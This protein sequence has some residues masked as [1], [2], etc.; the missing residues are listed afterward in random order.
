M[1][2]RAGRL[3]H[4]APPQHQK[5]AI[6]CARQNRVVPFGGQGERIILRTGPGVE[7]VKEFFATKIIVPGILTRILH[8][9]L[10]VSQRE[11]ERE[12][13]PGLSPQPIADDSLV[14]I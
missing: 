3:L 6:R 14:A 1:R 9:R 11:R 4:T 8:F 2:S 12:L 5:F 7:E 10:Q 13:R